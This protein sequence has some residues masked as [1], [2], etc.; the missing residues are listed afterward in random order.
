[1]NIDKEKLVK[2]GLFCLFFG[3]F[4]C[5]SYY[6]VI[7][8]ELSWCVFVLWGLDLIS[9]RY[10]IY[11]RKNLEN[12]DINLFLLISGMCICY[13][14]FYILKKFGINITLATLLLWI[15]GC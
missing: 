14:I 7:G 15:M 8:F 3:F 13:I 2:E 1:M 9:M 5:C 11:K 4:L 12:R 6:I 10:I